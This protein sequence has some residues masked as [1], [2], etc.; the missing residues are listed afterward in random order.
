MET[1]KIFQVDAFAKGIFSGNP[2]AVC[3]MDQITNK[4]LMQQI[5]A[6]NN[7]SETAFFSKNGDGFDL[8]WFTP[9]AEVDLCGHATLATAHVIFTETTYDREVISFH[10]KS[11]LLTVTRISDGKYAMDFPADELQEVD[12]PYNFIKAIGKQPLEI[13]KGKTD[14]LLLYSSEEDIQSINPNYGLLKTL[15]V[16][17]I[18]VTSSG[19]ETDFVS[20]FFCPAVGIN[21]DPATG[22]AHT[23]L[24]VFWAKKLNKSSFTARQLSKRKGFISCMLNGDRV[25]LT[26]EAFTYLKGEIILNVNELHQ[27]F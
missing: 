2:A 12:V 9:E 20:R 22:S 10:T 15:P 1:I 16:R 21:E 27:N 24:A 18:I 11:G 17:G 3:P 13:W 6:E 8:R 19:T 7:L 26:G 5:A 23:S 4:R 25:I 14:F